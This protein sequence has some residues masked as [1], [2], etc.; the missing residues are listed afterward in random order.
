MVGANHRK[1]RSS[2]AASVGLVL[3]AALTIAG[4]LPAWA[5][6][7]VDDPGIS[8]QLSP[9]SAGLPPTVN[10]NL[11]LPRGGT[12][13][14]A[15]VPST[16]ITTTTSTSTDPVLQ[17]I[18]TEQTALETL[19]EQVNEANE[20]QMQFQQAYDE[21]LRRSTDADAALTKARG[22]AD[23]WLRSTYIK[24]SRIPDNV[25]LDDGVPG[26]QRPGA[27]VIADSPM[28]RL[29]AAER[30][31]LAARSALEAAQAA[32][33]QQRTL[34]E[35]MRTQLT[36]RSTALTTLRTKYSTQ[37]NAAEQQ[38][39]KQNETIG[40]QLTN[41]G[42]GS[43][44]Q[45][46]QLA[47]QFAMAQLGKPYEWGA[48][49][50]DTYDCS[51]LVQAAYAYA[52]VEVPRTARPQFLATTPVPV[53]ALVPG[54]LLFFGPDKSN[55]QSI[56]HVGIYIGDGKMIHAPTTGD[57]VKIAPIWWEE[58]FGAT[59]VV[60]ATSTPGQQQSNSSSSPTPTTRPPTSA[61]TSNR[62]TTSPTTPGT[63]PTTGG[64]GSPT[65]SPTP[66]PSGPPTTSPTDPAS[67]SPSPS[68]SP[69]TSPSGSPSE[70][71]C[72]STSPSTSTSGSPSPSPSA[73]PSDTVSPSGSPSPSTSS[74]PTC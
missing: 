7:A 23:E 61:P 50:P 52:G 25:Q 22:E 11:Q 71:P 72:A 32:L 48:E 36:T 9:P 2:R 28:Q 57:V 18:A 42:G 35:G 19:S 29:T 46:A 27:P 12:P 4:P 10:G 5:A 73:T 64:P 62:P 65:G 44:A 13:G 26:F 40:N 34:V 47:I 68:Q 63:R 55:W 33:E 17:Q 30:A 49:G 69:S 45:A 14:A 67:E 24:A 16:S 37:L 66:S 8:S 39:N 43:P 41:P 59:R 58:F 74:S 3:G 53:S 1:R 38:R 56:H 31:A 21:A 51:G 60:P 15:T 54:D 6:P 70:S 20:L